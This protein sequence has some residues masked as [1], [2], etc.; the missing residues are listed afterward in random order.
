M[1]ETAMAEGRA[2]LATKRGRMPNMAGTMKLIRT[3]WIR[4]SP[5]RS[6]ILSNPNQA[7]AAKAEDCSSKS[8]LVQI[9]MLW[10]SCRSANAPAKGISTTFGTMSSKATMASQFVDLV[11]SQASQDTA[12][13]CTKKLIHDPMDPAE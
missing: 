5:A 3:P 8:V 13:S 6:Q 4:T 12:T 2:G 1:G 11:S 7:A 10:R 9:M